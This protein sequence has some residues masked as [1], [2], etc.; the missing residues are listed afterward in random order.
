MFG[1][2][3]RELNGIRL[4]LNGLTKAFRIASDG[5]RDSVATTTDDE[6]LA[7][8]E[9]RIEVVAGEVAAGLIKAD[10]L[11]A[12]A[13]AAEDRARGHLN[14]A[15]KTLELAEGI[16]GGEERDSFEEAARAYAAVNGATDDEAQFALPPVSSGLEGRRQSLTDVRS[17]KRGR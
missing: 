16:E 10:A 13:R 15:E 7:R 17:R 11:K 14:R 4:E 2:I 8:L 6:R 12:T 5:L 3:T 9:G 1:K